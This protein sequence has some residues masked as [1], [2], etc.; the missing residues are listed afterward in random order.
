MLPLCLFGGE[1]LC[2][3]DLYGFAIPHIPLSAAT[4]AAAHWQK[5]KTISICAR[6]LHQKCVTLAAEL[7]ERSEV[8]SREGRPV[9]RRT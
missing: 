5:F 8:S 4:V 3:Y 9:Y 2:V 6:F 7:S 1:L